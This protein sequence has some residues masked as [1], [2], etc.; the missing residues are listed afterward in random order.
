MVIKPKAFSAEQVFKQLKFPWH[1]LLHVWDLKP[2]LVE[3]G[4]DRDEF[5]V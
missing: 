4:G 3:C 1:L 2:T 5:F